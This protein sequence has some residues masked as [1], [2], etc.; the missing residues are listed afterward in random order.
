MGSVAWK[1]EPLYAGRRVR[2]GDKDVEIDNRVDSSQLP[3]SLESFRLADINQP[4]GPQSHPPVDMTV[5][6]DTTSMM[7]ST[8]FVS[9]ASFY[10]VG[11]PKPRGPL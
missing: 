3:T 8:K 6:H 7:S 2:I 1:G 4:S 10:G 5:E 11:K 9:P